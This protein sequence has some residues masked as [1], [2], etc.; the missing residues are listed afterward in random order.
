LLAAAEQILIADTW[1]SKTSRFISTRNTC[2]PQIGQLMKNECASQSCYRT[3]YDGAEK[4]AI[5]GLDGLRAFSVSL[6]MV[7]HA[8]FGN[9]VPGGLGVTVFFVLSGF[10]ITNLLITE[11]TNTGSLSIRNFYVRRYLRLTPELYVYLLF[12]MGA[13]I[14]LANINWMDVLAPAFYFAN[15]AKIFRWTS[16]E[17]GFPVDHFWSLAIEEHFYVAMPALYYLTRKSPFR[18]VFAA[19][20]Y[21][22]IVPFYRVY[23]FDHFA[24]SR[25]AYDNSVYTYVATE[26]RID[27]LLIGCV[28]SILCRY[29][30]AAISQLARRLWPVILVTSI[31]IMIAALLT[32][33]PTFRSTFRYSMQNVSIILFMTFLF[34]SVPG[35]KLIGLLELP[36]LKLLGRL[37]YGMYIWHLAPAHT[38]RELGDYVGFGNGYASLVSNTVIV[39]VVT[40]PVAW[41]S[42][43]YALAP[44]NKLRKRF[45]SVPH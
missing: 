21:I 43:R 6:V 31:V 42:E 24:V 4:S 35:A 11:W 18:F 15:Y 13:G 10:L 33:D 2:G 44:F 8:G 36:V 20:L 30:H 3:L 14:L 5:P 32:R 37:S 39:F 17:N 34:F 41:F 28:L 16:A 12:V 9:I 19:L 25:M 1:I 45:G 40:I 22:S 38:L 7:A 27:S 23:A 29:R 26:S